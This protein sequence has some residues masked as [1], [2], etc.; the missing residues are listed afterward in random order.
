MQ[1]VIVYLQGRRNSAKTEADRQAWDRAFQ[2]VMGKD[3]D[4]A[5]LMI[6]QELKQHEEGLSNIIRPGEPADV[7]TQRKQCRQ[8]MKIKRALLESIA[9]E[10]NNQRVWGDEW[11]HRMIGQ[12]IRVATYVGRCVKMAQK[13]PG[14]TTPAL[15]TRGWHYAYR[16]FQ[17][18]NADALIGIMVQEAGCDRGILNILVARKISE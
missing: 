4:E 9:S 18:G 6:R 7:S 1:D 14:H 13:F 8:Q 10:Y 11:L 16:M 17:V 5:I 2:A 15:A 3:P 12:D